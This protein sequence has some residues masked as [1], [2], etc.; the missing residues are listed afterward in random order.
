MHPGLFYFLSML[1]FWNKKMQERVSPEDA[2]SQM[3]Y[4][5]GV[6]VRHAAVQPPE[7]MERFL[8]R[9]AQE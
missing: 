3:L 4:V 9:I 1:F 8:T 2:M 7:N 6:A 5:A